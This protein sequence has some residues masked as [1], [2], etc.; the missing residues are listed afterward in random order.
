MSFALTLDF[1]LRQDDFVLEMHEQVADRAVGLYGRSG[2]GKTMVLDTVAGLRR[3]QRGRIQAGD[4]VLFDSEARVDLPARHRRVGYVPQDIALFPHLDVRRNVL[5]GAGRS[6][7]N[8][9][10]QVVDLLDLA[11]FLDR[12]VGQLS[13]GERQ[14]VAIARALMA[15]PDLLLLDEPLSALDVELRARV[16]PYLVRVRDD[17]RVPML[18]VSHRA[19]EVRAIADW[20]IRLERGRVTAAGPAEEV[21]AAAA[22]TGGMESPGQPGG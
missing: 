3:P 10:A 12:R 4:H 8:M 2:A 15:T 14:R 18:Y 17:L 6:T 11:P 22:G 16:L 13:G 5:Y 19:D 9:L 1:V 20:V 21:L 7:S